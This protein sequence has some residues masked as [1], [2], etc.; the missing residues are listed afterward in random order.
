MKRICKT[1]G[2]TVGQYAYGGDSWQRS[3]Y[4]K[5]SRASK[6]KWLQATSHLN[7]EY[8]EREREV[9]FIFPRNENA[10]GLFCRAKCMETYMEQMNEVIDRLPNL[11]QI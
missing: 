10:Q 3:Y 6:D 7:S 5:V 9:S 11:V 8:I 2:R 1:C 4:Q